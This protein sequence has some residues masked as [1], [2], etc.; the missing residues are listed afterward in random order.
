MLA[1]LSI[2]LLA[3]LHT[4]SLTGRDLVGHTHSASGNSCRTTSRGS[5][6]SSGL[7]PLVRLCYRRLGLCSKA[8][9]LAARGGQCVSASASACCK[10]VNTSS[11]ACR[12]SGRRCRQRRVVALFGSAA[13]ARRRAV[14]AAARR[15]YRCHRTASVAVQLLH[16]Q[17][18]HVRHAGPDEPVLLHPLVEQLSKRNTA[19]G[20]LWLECRLAANTDT[21]P[22]AM[23]PA[24][25]LPPRPKPCSTS[26][27]PCP[28]W[29]TRQGDRAQTKRPLVAD[30]GPCEY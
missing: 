4:R 7:R 18:W 19:P 14:D 30:E 15:R 6:G 10:A 27:S 22:N 17:R 3:E 23:T 8:L 29:R 11:V 21:L 12:P 26:G 25:P 1:P 2:Q 9:G 20:S 5:A 28:K 24:C 16:R 13:M